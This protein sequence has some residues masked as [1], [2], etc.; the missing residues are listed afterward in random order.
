M[1][2]LAPTVTFT[3]PQ[4]IGSAMAQTMSRAVL[5]EMSAQAAGSPAASMITANSSPP[6]L[7]TRPGRG[8]TLQSTC[9]GLRFNDAR[10][11]DG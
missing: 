9:K 2:T 11:S 1:P 7:A 8:T 5:A 3:A 6:S 4:E 10:A